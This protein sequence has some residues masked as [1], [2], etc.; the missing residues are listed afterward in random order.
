MKLSDYLVQYLV[1]HKIDNVFLVMGGAASH[2]VDSLGKN[3]KIKYICMQHE[4]AAAMAADVQARLS[5]RPSAAVATSGPGATNFITG[6]CTSWFDSIPCIFLT[7]Q[8]S[9]KETKGARKIRQLGFQETDIVEIIKSI[10]KYAVIVKDP[11]EIKYHL[12]K[13]FYLASAGRPGPVWLDLPL[14]I[15]HAEINPAKLKGFVP[16]KKPSSKNSIQHLR[17]CL[18]LMSTAK[19]P[20]IIGGHGI[21]LSGAIPQFAEFIK[22]LGWPVVLTWN[23][24]DILSHNHP[25]YVGQFGVYGSRAAN[26]TVQ[27]SDLIISIGSRLDT[28]QTGNNPQTFA[29][30]AQIISV[31]I[32][33]AELTKDWV[34]ID[35]AIN[36]SAKN[37]LTQVTK[38]VKTTN[39]ANI[40]PWWQKIKNWQE[41]FPIILPEFK[42]QKKSVSPYIFMRSLSEKLDKDD[43]ILVDSGAT[44]VWAYQTFK[45]KNGQRLINPLGNF[46]MGYA[47]PAGIGAWFATGKKRIICIIG[48]GAMQMNIQELQT[49]DYHKIPLKIFVINNHSYGIVKQFQDIYFDSRHEGTSYEKGYSCPD[50]LKIARGYNLSTSNIRVN[51]QIGQKITKCLNSPGPSLCD[52]LIDDDQKIIPKLGAVKT[53]KGYISKPIEDQLPLLARSVLRENMI[54]KS[55]DDLE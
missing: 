51:S 16:K 40:T 7:G 46:P 43:I 12:D 6:T 25:L 44:T 17:Q 28:R 23:G 37:F 21:R 55:I 2:L 20:V 39:Y 42:K 9:L 22:K 31:D 19:R 15:Q 1:D 34:K 53:A 24:I 54:I 11:K 32:D 3:K 45:V 47:L 50:F 18:K 5:G 30:D 49:V 29:R 10:T 13:A 27:N 26:F 36:E 52:V 41:Q 8:V 38:Q 4:Q 35:L 33:E 48:D 14:N